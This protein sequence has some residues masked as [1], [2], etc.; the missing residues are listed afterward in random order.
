MSDCLCAC[1][2]LCSVCG[3]VKRANSDV[4]N[5]PRGVELGQEGAEQ[6]RANNRQGIYYLSIVSHGPSI[7][8]AQSETPPA[9][10]VQPT[11][12][13]QPETTAASRGFWQELGLKWKCDHKHQ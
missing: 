13:S 4:P 5:V 6:G 8:I 1:L 3:L 11:N 9:V 12:C 10:S 7:I 2:P